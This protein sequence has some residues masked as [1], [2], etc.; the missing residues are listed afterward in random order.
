MIE[1]RVTVSDRMEGGRGG[2]GDGCGGGGRRRRRGDGGGGGGTQ[3]GGMP[4][5]GTMSVPSNMVGKVIGRGGE[6]IRAIQQ[7]SGAHVNIERESDS[8]PGS[9][10]RKVFI[11]GDP[12]AIE[13]ARQ[14]ELAVRT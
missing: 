10:E 9:T 1:D 7:R 5:T 8:A 2:P 11:T 3:A 14:C 12:M 4:S 13:R 6:N